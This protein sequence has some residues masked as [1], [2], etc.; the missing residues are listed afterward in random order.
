MFRVKGGYRRDGQATSEGRTLAM[1]A[2]SKGI[3]GG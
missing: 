2:K 1:N 3:L